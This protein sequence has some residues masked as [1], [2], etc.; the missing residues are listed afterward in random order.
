[1]ALIKC[2]ECG[3]EISDA[4]VKC[5]G[6]GYPLKAEQK[7]KEREARINQPVE[8]PECHNMVEPHLSECPNCGYKLKNGSEV[9]AGKIKKSWN[10]EKG[11]KIII[12]G[13][14]LIVLLGGF[15]GYKGI[16]NEFTQYTKYIGKDY[17]DLPKNLTHE[18]FDEDENEWI[19]QTDENAIE[20]CGEMGTLS[21]FYSKV[22]V[23]EVKANEIVRIA[24]IAEDIPRKKC[25]E[26]RDRLIKTYGDYNNKETD[27][28]IEYTWESK[29][30]MDITLWAFPDDDNDEEVNVYLWW[31]KEG[32]GGLL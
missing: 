14:M 25:N 32:L 9:V 15:I 5:P 26:I 31:E 1:M 8:C 29:K 20:I 11:R 17:S 12:A 13:I 3:K 28:T 18:K 10:S 21:Y 7:K 6:C 30:G 24:W 4:A 16:G 22:A 2:P 19:A 23:S 27:W